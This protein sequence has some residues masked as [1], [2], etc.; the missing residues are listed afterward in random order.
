MPVASEPVCRLSGGRR[1]EDSNDIGWFANART[2]QLG[3]RAG[4]RPR[5]GTADQLQ[6]LSHSLRLAE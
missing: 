1:P 3:A 6:R 2:G 5:I 4:E